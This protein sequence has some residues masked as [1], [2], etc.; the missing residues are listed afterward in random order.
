MDFLHFGD[1]LFLPN[2]SN[3]RLC[4][5]LNNIVGQGIWNNTFQ[6]QNTELLWLVDDILMTLNS[7]NVLCGSFGFYPSYVA[8][9]LN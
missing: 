4:E 8:G 1:V 9:I 6:V 3:G 2:S 7:D 5:D